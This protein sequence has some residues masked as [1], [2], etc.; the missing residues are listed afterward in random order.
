VLLSDDFEV[1]F[2]VKLNALA[3]PT[4]N[5]YENIMEIADRS[6]YTPLIRVHITQTTNLRVSYN[7]NGYITSGPYLNANYSGIYTKVRFAYQNG[8]VSLWTSASQATESHAV[9]VVKPTADNIYSI[10]VSG[11]STHTVNPWGFV[12]NMVVRGK[13]FHRD[14]AYILLL[15]ASV[16]CVTSRSNHSSAYC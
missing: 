9:D 14:I 16:L 15:P 3:P 11:V 12:R 7:N 8:T 4:G 5:G 13:S 2:D 10:S 6:D 1:I